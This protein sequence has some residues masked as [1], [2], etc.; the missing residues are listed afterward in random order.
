MLA[1]G[2]SKKINNRQTNRNRN[3]VRVDP[4][5]RETQR[6]IRPDSMLQNRNRNGRRRVKSRHQETIQTRIPRHT[7][8]QNTR[9]P[10]GRIRDETNGREHPFRRGNR[11]L[12]GGTT[13]E[14]KQRR[15]SRENEQSKQLENVTGETKE[16]NTK[17]QGRQNVLQRRRIF[18]IC[19]KTNEQYVRRRIRGGPRGKQ[20]RR[21]NTHMGNAPER[22]IPTTQTNETTLL[23]RW[24]GQNGGG[25]PK[26]RAASRSRPTE[27]PAQ[28]HIQISTE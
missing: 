12:P 26:R 16:T 21:R 15:S 1:R 20:H 28:H 24:K 9:V 7:R 10:R 25:E 5:R 14:D 22:G 27:Q 3:I 23:P 13:L 17:N 6:S 11:T 4:S 19:E 8:K 2:K 18:R